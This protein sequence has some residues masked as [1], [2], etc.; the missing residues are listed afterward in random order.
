MGKLIP[1]EFGTT[2]Q[3]YHKLRNS[4]FVDKRIIAIAHAQAHI[5]I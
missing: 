4:N 1:F 2:W 3:T 5:K